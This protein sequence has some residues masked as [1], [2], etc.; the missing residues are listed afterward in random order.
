MIDYTTVRRDTETYL[1]DNFHTVPIAFE[2]VPLAFDPIE[3]IELFDNI[4]DSSGNSLGS[5]VQLN[6]GVL[7]IAILTQMDTGT[8]RSRGIA[9]ELALLLSNKI[10]GSINFGNAELKGAKPSKDDVYFA[11][12]LHLS[13]TFGFGLQDESC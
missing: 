4:A 13:Y 6:S 11:Q 8:Q 12:Y 3:L 2:N 10:I 1:A 7:I 5:Q 9:S